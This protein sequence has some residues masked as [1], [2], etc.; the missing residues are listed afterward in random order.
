LPDKGKKKG[1]IKKVGKA[2]PS[3]PQ[4]KT[5]VNRERSHTHRRRMFDGNATIVSLK[6]VRPPRAAQGIPIDPHPA[7]GTAKSLDFSLRQQGLESPAFDHVIA[8]IVINDPNHHG[9]TS[10]NYFFKLIAQIGKP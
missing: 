2:Q 7:T 4:E 5:S 8:T 3:P 10:L 1:R 9:A 6:I